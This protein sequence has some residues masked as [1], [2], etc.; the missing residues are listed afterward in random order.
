MKKKVYFLFIAF[1]LMANVISAQTR[2]IAHRGFWDTKGSAQ[3]SIAALKKAQELN[4]YGSEFDVQITADGVL[5][6][7]HDDTI[8]GMTIEHT[9]YDK[10]KN[11]KLSNGEK[12]PTLDEYLAAG[13]EAKGI[14]L[15]LEIKPHKSIENENKAV[16]AS[17]EL[18]KKYGLEDRVEYISFSLN[19]CK[20]LIRLAPKA[21]V[22]YLRG[23]I[24]P[25]ELKELGFT[26]LD[27]HYRI[28]LNKEPEWIK[29]AKALGLSTNAWTVNDLEAMK[30]LIDKGVDFI[31]TD[32]PVE[33]KK[34]LDVNSKK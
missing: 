27:Y 18:V 12:L 33:L 15:I 1:I 31:T 22:S 26:G 24:S 10:L 2:V 8:G 19:I 25:D 5:V 17:I 28:L 9:N 6:V 11:I 20:E 14:M 32:K 4:L 34:L 16:S 7:N 3:N 29:E 21:Q 30:K 23:E 13:K